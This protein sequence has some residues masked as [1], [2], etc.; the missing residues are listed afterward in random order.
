MDEIMAMIF[1]FTK[2]PP[3]PEN[4]EGSVM[5][6]AVFLL[7]FSGHGVMSRLE[8]EHKNTF[9]VFKDGSTINMTAFIY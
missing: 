5:R 3:K 4:G 6:K 8:T 9:I 2:K 1:A 7:Y